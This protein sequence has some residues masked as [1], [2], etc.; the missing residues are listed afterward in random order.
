MIHESNN[1][2][3]IPYIK[4]LTLLIDENYRVK[5]NKELEKM[6]KNRGS[7]YKIACTRAVNQPRMLKEVL[8]ECY[9]IVL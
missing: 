6:W 9:D 3:L 5:T 4:S 7:V 8:N 2:T 1:V